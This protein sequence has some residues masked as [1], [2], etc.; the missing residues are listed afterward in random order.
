MASIYLSVFVN[1]LLIIAFII[2]RIFRLKSIKEY[3]QAKEAQIENLRLQ[4]ELERKNNDIELSELHKKRYQNLKLLLDEK[5]LELNQTKNSLLN[6]QDQ[7]SEVSNIL[8]SKDND[9][10]SH[11]HSLQSIANGFS[12]DVNNLLGSVG[13]IAEIASF[14]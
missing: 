3:Q 6:L 2:D 1:I 9:I 11:I 12:S 4:L 7:L 5:E 13:S 14:I 8:S 10:R